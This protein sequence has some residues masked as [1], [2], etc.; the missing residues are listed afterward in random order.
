V[1]S[2]E[3]DGLFQ[4]MERRD[5]PNV[6]DGSIMDRGV[7]AASEVPNPVRLWNNATEKMPPGNR[8]AF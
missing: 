3:I 7:I 6:C 4:Q 1:S 5:V 8:T 2:Y